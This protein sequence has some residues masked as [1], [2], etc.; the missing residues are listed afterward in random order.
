MADEEALAR[1]IGWWL[2]E[3]D[4]RLDAAF[5]RAVHDAGIDRRGWQVLSVV[6]VRPT[7]R[8]T[9]LAALSAFDSPEAVGSAVQE[10]MTQGLVED[11]SGMLRLTLDGARRHAELSPLV[12]AVR[13]KVRDALP[14]DDY[15]A[16][17]ALLARLAEALEPVRRA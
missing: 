9:I 10:L 6:A 2:K 7:A 15:T 17:V 5:D 4:A 14:Q 3:A 8:T 11:D 12:D 16:L 13:Q 1:P